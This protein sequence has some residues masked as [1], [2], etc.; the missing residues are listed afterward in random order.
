MRRAAFGM[1]GNALLGFAVLIGVS[2]AGLNIPVGL[3]WFSA[4]VI[5]TL[6]LPGL[7]VLVFARILL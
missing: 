7:G 5:T 2:V 1:L 6:G 3:T 4:L